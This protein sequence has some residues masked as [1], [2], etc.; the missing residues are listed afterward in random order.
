MSR[1]KFL[2]DG[3]RIK[4]R[5]YNEIVWFNRRIAA[6]FSRSEKA[7]MT[8]LKMGEL[9]GVRRPTQEAIQR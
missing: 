8:F 6:A 3:K 5:T 7:V 2:N 9:Y 4:V 1:W